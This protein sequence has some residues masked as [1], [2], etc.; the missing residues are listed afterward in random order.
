MQYQPRL[1][2]V[3]G[4]RKR[5]RQWEA[6]REAAAPYRPVTE[7][8]DTGKPVNLLTRPRGMNDVSWEGEGRDA[9]LDQ[10]IPDTD[11]SFGWF[12]APTDC[13]PGDL[14]EHIEE[15]ERLSKLGI[16]LG[17]LNGY[18]H[19]YLATGE[20]APKSKLRAKFLVR[21]FVPESEVRPLVEKLPKE[22]LSLEALWALSKRKLGPDRVC[23]AELLRKMAQFQVESD[24]VLQKYSTRLEKA[25][26][27]LLET[28]ESYVTLHEIH[29]TVIKASKGYKPVFPPP[30]HELYAIHR[31]IT[32]DDV[33]FRPVGTLADSSRSWLFE[34]TP[35]EDADLIQSMRTLVRRFTSIPG[36]EKTSLAS[37]EPEH[38]A[39]SPIGR[40]VLKAREAI[41]ESRLY[42]DWTPH[43]MLGP[44]KQ[45][46]PPIHTAWGEVEI[47]ILHFMLLWSA[48]DQFSPSAQFHWIGSAI[49]RATGKYKETD[50]LSATTG[51]VFLQEVGYITPW[52]LHERYTHRLP[53]VEVSRRRGFAP[54]PLGPEGIRPYLTRDVFDG[55]R[56]DWGDM[57]VFAIDSRDTTDID[58]AVSIETTDVPGEHWVHIHVADP[59]ARIR[60]QCALGERPSL[61]PMTLYLPGHLTNMWGVGDEVQ[62]LCSLGPNKS[63][64]TFSGR[65]NEQGEL[66][67]YKITPAKLQELI[68]MTPEDAN[69][70][71]GSKSRDRPPAWAAAESFIVGQP[72]AA[73]PPGR[74]ITT[75][76]ELQAEDLKSLETLYAVGRN[77]QERRLANGALP[78]YTSRPLVKASFDN[79]SVEQTP[80]G[81]MTCNGDP[82]ITLSW[83]CNASDMVTS[84]M[85]LAGEIAGRWC[86]DR[87]IPIAYETQPTAD[88][89]LAA[90]KAYTQEVYYPM[91]LRGE[92]P[93]GD[94]FGQ[95]RSLVG[96]NE[97]STKP[98]RNFLM[99]VTSYAKVTSPLRRYSDLLAHW[100]IEAAL[101]HEMNDEDAA[102]TTRAKVHPNDLPF[103][104]KEL[105]RDVF[106]QLRLRERIIR[107]LGNRGNEAY[108]LQAMLRAWKLAPPNADEHGAGAEATT[109]INSRLPK[110]FR[111]TT[112]RPIGGGGIGS[113]PLKKV[114]YGTLD[115]FGVSA[116]MV[117]EGL[118]A[119]GVRTDDL[120]PGDVYEVEL[121]DINVHLGDVLV[122]A[123]QVIR[124]NKD[125]EG[126]GGKSVGADGDG[127]VKEIEG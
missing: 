89:N 110:T 78:Y 119:L 105:E 118:G 94:M 101:A 9:A 21:N 90:V 4:I 109:T 111:L 120:R 74:K 24:E 88:A 75:P 99:G 37:L 55:R 115:W 121:V 91:L 97:L 28:G 25:H 92:Q 122:R 41:D 59:A 61:T 29:E 68:Y 102:T 81:L 33:G 72:P 80:S 83:D 116:V 8:N 104:G 18:Y 60:H 12:A 48:Y 46:R 36:K 16:C 56:H 86:A 5:L 57:K 30:A 20:W 43:G 85:Q 13:R 38:L 124:M 65:V 77:I 3:P 69:T 32:I 76:A 6:E 22:R 112:A 96:D 73:T 23:G 63:C 100:Q 35:R 95:L 93:D 26:D 2:G 108:I 82:T 1:E 71:T 54:L 107:Q 14:V 66:L 45:A 15:G 42:R 79:T 44:A 70:A 53:G 27:L 87:N 98:G 52:D 34:V 7:S 51:W 49:L 67:D 123:T 125:L 39:R 40:F 58:D 103:S 10:P 127:A 117:V 64:L 62:K 11:G 17:F 106:P 19:F 47:S 114:L 31:T 113:G 126:P 84:I 50:Y